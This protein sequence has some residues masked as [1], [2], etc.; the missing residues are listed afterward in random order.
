MLLTSAYGIGD[1]PDSRLGRFTPVSNYE[2][3]EW[4]PE[5]LDTVCQ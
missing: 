4:T 2:D 5:S 1:W 3:N